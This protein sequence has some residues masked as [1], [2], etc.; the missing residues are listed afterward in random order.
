[1]ASRTSPDAAGNFTLAVFPG[2]NTIG[3]DSVPDGYTVA[4]VTYDGM[5]LQHSPLRLNAAPASTVVVTVT[6][7]K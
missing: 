2:D 1:M 7:T 3:F 5:D 4:S 6:R